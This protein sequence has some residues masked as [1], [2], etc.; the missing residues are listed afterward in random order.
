MG[1]LET[2]LNGLATQI[3]SKLSKKEADEIFQKKKDA[4]NGNYKDLKNKPKFAKIATSG[5]WSDIKNGPY[6]VSYGF[7]FYKK[8]A[9]GITE[10]ESSKKY[11]AIDHRGVETSVMDLYCFMKENGIYYCDY[12]NN[13]KYCHTPPNDIDDLEIDNFYVFNNIYW[14][15]GE[16]KN[17]IYIVT[18]K[19]SDKIYIAK[20]QNDFY[21]SV[22]PFSTSVIDIMKIDDSL[23]VIPANSNKIFKTTDFGISWTTIDVS[24]EGEINAGFSCY[25]NSTNKKFVLLAN[26]K[27]VVVCSQ[28][29]TQHQI[30]LLPMNVSFF[31][32]V[33]TDYLWFISSEGTH[34]IACDID[35]GE[36]SISELPVPASKIIEGNSS[37][38]ASYC[39]TGPHKGGLLFYDGTRQIGVSYDVS[40]QFFYR[41]YKTFAQVFGNGSTFSANF[42]VPSLFT[43]SHNQVLN[44]TFQQELSKVALTGSYNDL[45]NKPTAAWIHSE[46]AGDYFTSTNVM[47]QLQELG[48]K[49]KEL[50]AKIPTKTSQLENDSGFMSDKDAVESEIANIPSKLSELE[51]DVGYLTL[52]TLPQT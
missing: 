52:D 3:K 5:E 31:W 15:K 32:H 13:M 18:I 24:I 6:P 45:N 9:W 34:Y 7:S 36:I 25:T 4:F 43:F 33:N 42:S 39:S 48:E 21:S 50:S 19:N 16:G 14:E 28:D 51:N 22:L 29:F 35:S 26:N 20:G 12:T 38:W 49:I 46:D 8:P 10:F 2:T 23:V 41:D 1:W 47:G 11:W 27:L 17:T 44:E 40:G 37:Y 30:F